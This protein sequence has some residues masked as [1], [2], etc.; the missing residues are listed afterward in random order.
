MYI[1]DFLVTPIL[2]ELSLAFGGYTAWTREDQEEARDA[3]FAKPILDFI[4]RSACHATLRSLHIHDREVPAP[5]ELV[6]IL[7]PLE[8]LTDLTLDGLLIDY[9]AVF[10]WLHNASFASPCLPRLHRLSLFHFRPSTASTLEYLSAFLLLPR[11]HPSKL[12]VLFSEPSCS[13]A[14]WRRKVRRGQ[15]AV[16]AAS[17]AG[18]SNDDDSGDET[19]EGDD[20]DEGVSD[21]DN[22][23][24]GS[25]SESETGA[26][27]SSHEASP[28]STGAADGTGSDAGAHSTASE[29]D[30]GQTGTEECE[31]DSDDGTSVDSGDS[32]DITEPDYAR[33]SWTSADIESSKTLLQNAHGASVTILARR[34]SFS[35]DGTWWK[36]YFQADNI[37]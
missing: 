7:L 2:E 23:K 15:A 29:D 14:M 24:E 19:D 28:G 6:S 8:H 4:E 12:S 13:L 34:E 36:Y 35:Y 37:A 33:S 22:S 5:K 11:L 1:L 25:D 18:E 10:F 27:G 16:R 21:T 30:S 26:I 17:D 31:S 9:T 32:E 3:P 20:A